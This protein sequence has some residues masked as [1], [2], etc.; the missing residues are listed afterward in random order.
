MSQNDWQDFQNSEQTPA[1]QAILNSV[2]TQI[3]KN[4]PS[5]AQVFT[6]LL[7]VHLF[8]TGF[9]LI[10]CPQFG[11]RLFFPSEARS[12]MDVF[13]VLGHEACLF[14]CGAFYLGT[15]FLISKYILSPDCWLVVKRSRF[16]M[17][18]TLALISLGFFRMWGDATSFE[19][20]VLWLLGAYLGAGLLTRDWWKIRLLSSPTN[21]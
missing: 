11:L 7:L 15:S 9:T 12:L 16:V 8:A 21:P 18:M 17:T 3:E 4:Q 1:P 19:L 2:L 10:A 5:L 13:M 14:L 6:K 20:T